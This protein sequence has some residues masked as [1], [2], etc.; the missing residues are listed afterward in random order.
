MLLAQVRQCGLIC[1]SLDLDRYIDIKFFPLQ[2]HDA[3]ETAV[4]TLGN[5]VQY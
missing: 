1:V 3:Y 5:T 4:T 2:Q